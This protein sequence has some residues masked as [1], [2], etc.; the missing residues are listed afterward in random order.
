MSYTDWTPRADRAAELQWIKGRDLSNFRK[1]ALQNGFSTVA[2][3]RATLDAWSKLETSAPFD[4][5]KQFPA[6]GTYICVDAGDW[7][8]KVMQMVGALN[9]KEASEQG[10]L[11]QEGQRENGNGKG[12][13]PASPQ[14]PEA[15][16]PLGQNVHDKNQLAFFQALKRMADQQF[17][18]D[19]AYSRH[20]FEVAYELT[21]NSGGDRGSTGAGIGHKISE[22]LGEKGGLEKKALEEASKLFGKGK[23]TASAS[24]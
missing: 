18:G 13:E 6:Y 12:K 16:S 14:A 1:L 5:D 8:D 7:P 24:K 11:R 15:A 23:A 9:Y 22:V 20:D 19:N 17:R 10:Q 2:G 3:R 21:W 4:V